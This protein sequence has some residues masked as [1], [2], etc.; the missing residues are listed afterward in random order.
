MTFS[1]LS[2]YACAHVCLS[3]GNCDISDKERT[4]MHVVRFIFETELLAILLISR[5]I[6]IISL[7]RLFYFISFLLHSLS[8]FLLNLLKS[9]FFTSYY[10]T[11]TLILVDRMKRNPHNHCLFISCPCVILVQSIGEKCLL[12]ITICKR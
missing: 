4:I 6:H 11:I 9:D 5:H 3:F 7:Q 2:L 10:I 12:T 8:H 1:S